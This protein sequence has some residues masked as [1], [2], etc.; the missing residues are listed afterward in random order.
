MHILDD[1]LGVLLKAL[2]PACLLQAYAYRLGSEELQELAP[3]LASCGTLV[4]DSQKCGNA[5]R[6]VNCCCWWVRLAIP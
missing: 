3:G 4:L 1:A 5:A 2:P 6:F